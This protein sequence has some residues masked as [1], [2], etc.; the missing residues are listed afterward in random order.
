MD[1]MNRIKANRIKVFN[2]CIASSVLKKGIAVNL[3]KL[4]NNNK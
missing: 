2:G 3:I 1:E 4:L